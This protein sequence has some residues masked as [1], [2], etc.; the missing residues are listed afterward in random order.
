MMKLKKIF[1]LGFGVLFINITQAAFT[2]IDVTH[3]YFHGIEFLREEE[4]VKGFKIENGQNIFKPREII[5]RVEALKII[6]LSANKNINFDKNQAPSFPDV[7]KTDWFFPYVQTAFDAGIV[8]GFTDK[9]FHPAV[10][11]NRAEFIKMLIETFDI[12]VK[13]KK[14]GEAWYSPYFKFA[15]EFRILPKEGEASE[16]LTRGEAAEIIYRMV[17]VKKKDYQAPYLYSGFGKASYY[18]EGFA[19]KP[20]ANGEKYNPLD[21]TAAHRTL[22]F[23]TRLK[24]CNIKEE[25]KCVVVRVN[26]RGP[27]HKSRILDLSEGAFSRLAVISTGVISVDFEIFSDPRDEAFA[28]PE[29][30][31]PALNQASKEVVVPTEFSKLLRPEN[32]PVDPKVENLKDKQSV[33]INQPYFRGESIGVIGE[34][35][36]PKIKLRTQIPQKVPQGLVMQLEGIST[37][38]KKRYK[39]VTVFLQSQNTQK[40]VLFEGPVSGKNFSLPIYFFEDGK[41]NLGIIFD[42]QR[43]SKIAEIEVVKPKRERRFPT[44]NINFKSELKLFL[45]P[46]NQ[47]VRAEWKSKPKRLTKLVYRQNKTKKGENIFESGISSFMFPYSF[48]N[49]FKQED[50]I[51]SI[52][53]YQADSK[54]GTLE[55]QFTNWEKVDYQNYELIQGFKDLEKKSISIPNFKR[56]HRIKKTIKLKGKV[57]DKEMI[58]SEHGYLTLPNGDVKKV[59]LVFQDGYFY[60]IFKPETQG[61]YIV[62]IIRDNGEILF[63]RAIYFNTFDVLPVLPNSELVVNT[64]NHTAVY[65]WINKLRAQQNKPKLNSDINIKNIAQEYAERMATENFLSHTD[66]QGGTTKERMK[67]SNTLSF[68][69]N[70]SYGTSLNLALSGLANSGSHRYNIISDR[71]TKMGVGISQNEEGHFYVVQIFAK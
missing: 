68:G 58:L 8:K 61:K 28:I 37:N 19:G 3:P 52:D 29:T 43:E 39:R 57:L 13:E 54:N 33:L 35:F 17:R 65:N 14:R 53:V 69:E 15:N 11:V 62:E 31:R 48:F 1:L 66:P 59:N 16:F 5:N 42:N 2:D 24:V 6:L 34:K 23:N 41:Q 63:N 49:R 47:K 25:D 46:E 22:P 27:Y 4:I 36:F 45:E 56:Y 40:Q 51:L 18:N 71:W 9:K 20:T 50:G 44:Q 38:E 12:E 30:L 55:K 32:Q 7:W 70:L 26:D 64:R 21:L 67:G 10:Q 60:F